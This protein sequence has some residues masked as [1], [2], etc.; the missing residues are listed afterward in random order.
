MTTTPI[1]IFA[2]VGRSYRA[3]ASQVSPNDKERLK[4]TVQK[5]PAAVALA[6]RSVKSRRK[7]WGSKAFARK[8]KAWGK[9]AVVQRKSRA[10]RTKLNNEAHS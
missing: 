4:K 10:R 7:K 9:L 5:D 2:F 8:M 1:S 6:M 3:D